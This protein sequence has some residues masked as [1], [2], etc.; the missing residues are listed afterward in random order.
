MKRFLV[1]VGSIY[2]PSGGMHD[3]VADYDTLEDAIGKANSKVDGYSW[4]HVYDTQL[5]DIV[6]YT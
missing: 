5:R 4:A 2:Y 6:W 3:F 1:F